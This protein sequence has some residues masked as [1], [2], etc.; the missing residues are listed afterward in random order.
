MDDFLANLNNILGSRYLKLLRSKAEK[1]HKE[2]LQGSE[3]LDEWLQMQKNWIYLE[4]I[5]ASADIKIKLKDENSLFE[6]V[7]KLFKT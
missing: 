5:F 3:T 4:N 1:L 6:N 7:D 2:V